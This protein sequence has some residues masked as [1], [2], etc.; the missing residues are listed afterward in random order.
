LR[1]GGSLVAPTLLVLA[2]VVGLGLLI[3][4]RTALFQLFERPSV[5]TTAALPAQ[6]PEPTSTAT[7][8]PIAPPPHKEEPAQL[9]PRVF[10]IYS[11]S[12]SDL[13]ELDALPGRAP[14]PRIA[15]S[16]VITKTSRTILPDGRI[17]FVAYRR[18]FAASAP[19]RV[20][21]RVIAKI[22]RAMNFGS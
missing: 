13:F 19:E 4:Q 11:I 18:D 8:V 2:L 9:L 21:V 20:S 12:N 7:S 22:T 17:S 1:V 5:S 15:L 16:A 14:D 10:A 3:S 6:T